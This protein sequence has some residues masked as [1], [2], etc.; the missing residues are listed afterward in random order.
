[1]KACTGLWIVAPITRAVDDKT[2]KNLLGDAFKRQLKFDGIQSAVS[3]ICSKTDDISI[4]EAAESLN[5]EEEVQGSWERAEDLKKQ[6]DSLK[7]EL[8]DW[9]EAKAVCGEK[10]DECEAKI[11]VW[12]D[13]DNNLR[14]G[15]TIYA[16]REKK[17]KRQDRR[18]KP[19]RKNLVS[20]D[21]ESIYSDSDDGSDK[22]NSQASQASQNRTPLTE[23]DITDALDRLRTEKKALRGERRGADKKMAEIRG[24]M[25]AMET[26]RESLLAE[27]KAACIKGR[28][29]YS[30]GAIKQ[31][32]AM[33]VKEYVFLG[34]LS[35]S[36]S[37]FPLPPFPFPFPLSLSPSPFPLPALPLP[38]SAPLPLTPSRKLTSLGWTR[39]MRPKTT[40]IS[41]PR[42]TCVTTTRWLGTSQSFASA[43]ARTKS[44]PGI[45]GRTTFRTRASCR[46]RIR[47]FPNCKSMRRS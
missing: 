18:P 3:F 20:S 38:L 17:R 26:E 23:E 35:L 36:P 29:E 13:L 4:T 43:A 40:R 6:K 1:M 37:P 45:C 22:E 7:R 30:R 8:V 11:D 39:R 34:F 33:G 31:D 24:E 44:F 28:N 5:M 32:F 2:A 27:V 9:R 47:R 16:P 41:T 42:S 12:E 25:A 15:M 14:M 10:L 19:S 21:V 46:P